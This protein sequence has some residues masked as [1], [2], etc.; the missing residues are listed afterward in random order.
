MRVGGCKGQGASARER[1]LHFVSR[2]GYLQTALRQS[3]GYSVRASQTQT[4]AGP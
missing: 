2:S 1:W 3:S 4:P